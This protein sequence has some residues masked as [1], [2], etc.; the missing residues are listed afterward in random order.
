MLGTISSGSFLPSLVI[1]NLLWLW[2]AI[3]CAEIWVGIPDRKLMIPKNDAIILMPF[4]D[5]VKNRLKVVNDQ[6]TDMKQKHP[7]QVA[8]H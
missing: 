5:K 3:V 7:L 8:W 4:I 2:F 1:I 6:A